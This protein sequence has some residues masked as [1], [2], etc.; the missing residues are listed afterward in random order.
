MSLMSSEEKLEGSLSL[1]GLT[2]R[3]AVSL[4]ILT[5]LLVGGELASYLKLRYRPTK[6]V[7]EGVKTEVFKGVSW[8]SQYFADFNAS[9]PVRYHSYILWRRAPYAGKTINI[10]AQGL[11]VTANIRCE[12]GVPSI[13]MFGNSALW[14]SG[15]PD[16][17]TI[18]SLLAEDFSKSGQPV[19]VKNFGEKAWV[20]TQEV[21]ALMLELKHEPESP[22]VVVF[23]D[24][25]TDSYLPYE[26]DEPDVHDNF[27]PMRQK[28]EDTTSSSPGFQ[29]LK[30]TNTYVFLNQTLRNLG[31]RDPLQ[32][33]RRTSP[34]QASTMAK[35]TVDNYLKNLEMVDALASHYG[36]HS[37]YFWQPTVR[38]GKK[39]LTAN[40]DEMRRGEE[41]LQP[42]SEIV[43]RATYD[44]IAQV[45][46][47]NLIDLSDMFAD[48]PEPLFVETNH[49]GPE[50]NDLV[51]R[52]IFQT[53][54]ESGAVQ[55]F[56]TTKRSV[57]ATAQSSS[58][59]AEPLSR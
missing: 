20:S 21:I 35:T 59:L 25:P 16:W 37:F 50:G 22:A 42:G 57:S 52:R 29:F 8:T 2:V 18:P 49:L 7:S 56:A 11:R 31:M 17:A 13:W 46:R 5:L 28:F 15:T 45:H 23:Y 12:P 6:R 51:A 53:I 24:G 43:F 36:F 34:E 9:S 14:G 27:E 26:S 19:C 39:S 47:S 3:L 32:P 33:Q 30:K 38:A 55:N 4:A 10:D 48:H 1:Q 44:L 41:A 54:L 40:E 58:T